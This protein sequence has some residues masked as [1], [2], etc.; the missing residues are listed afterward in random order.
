MLLNQETDFIFAPPSNSLLR[1]VV[2]SF[3]YI[4]I[5]TEDLK[6]RSESVLPSPRVTFG[7]FFNH[8]FHII[9]LTKGEYISGNSLV[10]KVSRDKILVSP[11][12]GR[13]QIF[14]IHLKPYALG[15]F[16]REKISGMKWC[17][18]PLGINEPVAR[19]FE[20]K[21][22][23]IETVS[24]LFG[25][26][27]ELLGKALL[28]I[29]YDLVA[30]TV[31]FIDNSQPLPT[32]EEIAHTMNITDRTLRNTFQRFVGCSPKEYLQTLRALRAMQIMISSGEKLT[33]NG[34][35]AGYYDQSHFI[36]SLKSSMGKI[37][38]QIKKDLANHR[39]I[40]F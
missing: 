5:R 33:Q 9:N 32:V 28:N 2:L 16:T 8:P 35:H 21:V 31:S 23:S 26:A 7:Y 17:E 36:S 10:S 13:V 12:T 27:E 6:I 3:F 24:D 14:G 29:N 25:F 37:P 40:Y 38:K 34:Y 18:S 15:L 30:Q 19:E 11:V 22:S 1:D 4:N 39:F 20:E